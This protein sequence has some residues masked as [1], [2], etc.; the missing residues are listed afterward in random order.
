M[1]IC[2]IGVVARMLS[3]FVASFL[4]ESLCPALTTGSEKTTVQAT[5]ETADNQ[6]A[7]PDY[8]RLLSSSHVL[9]AAVTSAASQQST[10]RESLFPA[11]G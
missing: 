1:Y 11:C 8:P 5:N 7:G 6:R 2:H 10:I 4:L 3:A 9:L